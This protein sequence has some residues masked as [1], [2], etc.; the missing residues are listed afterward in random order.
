MDTTKKLVLHA[1][2]AKELS[3]S[4]RIIILERQI[5]YFN[6]TAGK[7]L[8]G[9]ETYETIELPDKGN[10]RNISRIP[11]G[12]YTWQ[13]IK[14]TSNGDNAILLRDV[15]NRSEILIHF[16]TKPTDSKGCILVQQYEHLHKQLNSKGLIVIL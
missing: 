16:G 12:V 8:V 11:K 4:K 2:A 15:P 14:R 10:Q 13:K 5:D 1:Y 7:I 3:S 6:S 9:S